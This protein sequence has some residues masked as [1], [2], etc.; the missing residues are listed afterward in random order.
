MSKPERIIVTGG[1]GFI[2]SHAVVELHAAGYV[3]IVVDDFSNSEASVLAGLRKIVGEEVASHQVDC[4]DEAALAAVFEA[5]GPIRGV[6]HFA[7]FKAVGESVQNPLNYYYNNLNSL[8]TLLRVMQ[9]YDVRDLVFSSSCTVYGQP[10]RLPV[11]EA[12][13]FLPAESPYGHTKQICEA[14]LH[15]A[16]RAQQP[17]RAVSLRYFNPIGAHPSGHIGELPRGVPSNL[18]PFITQTAAGLRPELSVF[19]NDYPTPDGTCVRD[20][21]HVVDL[22]RAHVQ[23]FGW[24]AGRADQPLYEVFNVGTGWGSSVL[25][26]I[27]A[28]E[29]ASGQALRYRI[30][31][32]RPGDVVEIYGDVQKAQRTLGWRAELS[33][34]T[35]MGDAWR[36]EQRLQKQRAT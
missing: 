11:T 12:A 21:I 23:A 9:R 8:L 28:F 13:P 35:A 29:R 14:M 17:L 20:Y 25:E 7:A 24:L 3:P 26:V 30:A 1:A 5:E 2:G 18:V 31:P 22:A 36:W 15:D 16:V 4:N 33:L 27:H 32:R 10:A 19:G 6:I 34:A